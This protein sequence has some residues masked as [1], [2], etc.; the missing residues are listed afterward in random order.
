MVSVLVNGEEHFAGQS[1]AKSMGDLIELVK[2]S[3]DP[4]VMITSINLSGEKLV[5]QDWSRSVSSLDGEVVQILTGDPEDFVTERI[6][7]SAD[8]ISHIIAQMEEASRFFEVSASFEGSEKFKE[9]IDEFQAFLG[10]F[11]T[12]FALKTNALA[13][14]EL[15]FSA[16]V[17]EMTQTSEELLQLQLHQSWWAISETI[18]KGLVPQLG[19]LREFCRQLVSL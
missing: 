19:V 1:D 17:N 12:L 4:E 8:V 16:Y 15:Q 5:D 7:T 2:A 6:S 9:A 10:W 3:M 11:N 14:K 13:G 18:K